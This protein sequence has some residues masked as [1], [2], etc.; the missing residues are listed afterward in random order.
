MILQPHLSRMKR[1]A[2]VVPVMFV[3]FLI[4]FLYY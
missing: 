1:T 2:F 4:L 3:V